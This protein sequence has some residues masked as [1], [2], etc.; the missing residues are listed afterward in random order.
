MKT[1][2]VTDTTGRVYG[3]PRRDIKRIRA[4]AK[5]LAKEFQRVNRET[6][7]RQVRTA[8]AKAIEA[9]DWCKSLPL[10]A[11]DRCCV[12]APG[13]TRTPGQRFRKPLLYPPELRGQ[14]F[15]QW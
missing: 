6:S 8:D 9:A 5:A 12:S 1:L 15:V 2:F 7:L 13:V 14:K 10:I 3:A 11:L 4:D